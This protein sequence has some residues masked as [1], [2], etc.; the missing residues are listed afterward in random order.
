MAAH[1]RAVDTPGAEAGG[2][3]WLG[4]LELDFEHRHGRTIVARSRH[5]GPFVVQSAFYPEGAPC[6]LYLLHPP[7]GLVGGDRLELGIRCA[8]G[9]HA[10]ITTPAAGK[11]YRS[12]GDET[13]VQQHIRIAGGAT[14]EFLPAECIVFDGARCSS[15]THLELESGAAVLA[16]EAWVM[17][18]PA[19]GHTFQTGLLRQSMEVTLDGRPIIWERNHVHGAGAWLHAPWGLGGRPA[20]VSLVAFPADEL[21]LGRARDADEVP[22]CDTGVSLMEGVLSCRAVAE[23]AMVLRTQMERWWRVLRPLVTGLEPVPPRVWAT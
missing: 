14:V 19:S 22:G 9:S 20:C 16:W 23:S 6:H 2:K 10:L 13:H 7:G 18:R 1:P 5:Q 21:T 3:G 4:E 8:R 11:I 15:A 17:G 12:A